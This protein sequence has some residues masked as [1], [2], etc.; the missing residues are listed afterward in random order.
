VLV[1]N[2]PVINPGPDYPIAH[3]TRAIIIEGREAEMIIPDGR[4]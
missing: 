3:H 2:A 1:H 4:S